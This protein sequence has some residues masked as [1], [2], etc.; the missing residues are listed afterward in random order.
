MTEECHVYFA[1]FGFDAEPMEITLLAGIE[2]DVC[3]SRG[4]PIT[5]LM[6]DARHRQA[7][8][9]LSSGLDR[10]ASHQDHFE[11]LY[12]RL[13]R[14]GD[15]LTLMRSRYRS[16]LG[17]SQYFFFEDARFYLPDSLIADY[18][19][20]GIPLSFDQLGLDNTCAPSAGTS[21]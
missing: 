2:P 6:P 7:R 8:W 5:P 17:V 9:L 3:W 12:Y 18:E 1:V 13:H 15:R 21:L 4:D 11:K 10:Y 20:L 16:G 14:L 19:A